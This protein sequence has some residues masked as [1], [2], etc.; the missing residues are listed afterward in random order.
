MA[1]V[2]PKFE[3]HPVTERLTRRIAQKTD[4]GV[5]FVEVPEDRPCYDVFFPAGHSVRIHGDDR[6]RQ[7]GFLEPPEL[8]DE[9]TG[10]VVGRADHLSMKDVSETK[11]R[12]KH[13]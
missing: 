5:E 4:A 12:R 9:E 7:L 8:V 10:D 13:S 1:K 6:M 3:V 2:V 11:T